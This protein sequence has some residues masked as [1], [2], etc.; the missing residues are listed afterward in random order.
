MLPL[1]VNASA[2]SGDDDTPVMFDDMK[3]LPKGSPWTPPDYS[4]QENAIGYNE[5][6]FEVPLSMQERVSFW[7]DIYTKFNTDQ[8]LLHDSQYVHLIYEEV[9]FT[10][11]MKNEN[12][13]LAQKRRA[14]RKLVKQKK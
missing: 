1:A 14:R 8:G 11:I 13:S 6:T 2:R 9:D 7:M 12:L 10:Q 4:N 3:E 5:N